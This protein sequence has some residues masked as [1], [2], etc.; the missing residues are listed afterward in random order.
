[1][2]K[3]FYRASQITSG[4]NREGKLPIS[5]ATLWRW[6]KDPASNFPKPIKLNKGTTVWDASEIDEFIRGQ[7]N[8]TK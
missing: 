6:S 8:Q 2:S 1:M 3:H 4:K 5:L 7:R